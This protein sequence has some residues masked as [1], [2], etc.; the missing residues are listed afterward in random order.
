MQATK[1]PIRGY[2]IKDVILCGV[3]NESLFNNFS[4]LALAFHF[5]FLTEL[6]QYGY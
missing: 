5:K 3:K 1:H 4:S 2:K 6:Q